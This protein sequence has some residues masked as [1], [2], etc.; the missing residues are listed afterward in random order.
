MQ[1][2]R[3]DVDLWVHAGLFSLY[4]GTLSVFGVTRRLDPSLGSAAQ[5]GLLLLTWSLL[6]FAVWRSKR[7]PLGGVVLLALLPYLHM[8]YFSATGESA[9]GAFSYLY[10]FSGFLMA[11]YLWVWA[12]FRDDDQIERTLMLVA[13]LLAARAVL[14]FAVPGLAIT[15]GGFADDFTVYEWVGPLPR[16]FY[17]GMPLVFFGLMVSLRNLFLAADRQTTLE[18]ARSVL[19]AAALAVNLSR[20]I[21]MFAVVVTSLLLLVKFT[22]SRVAAGRKGRLVLMSLLALTGVTLVVVATPLSDT[23]AQVASG[24]SNQ[25]RFSLDQGNLDWRV[26]QMRAAYRMVETPEERALGVGTNTFIPESIEHPVPGEV[27][28]ELH[29]S[30]DS[31][32]WTFGVAGLALLVGFALLQ[33]VLRVL[34]IRPTSPLILPV[35][36]TGSFIA[37]VGLYTVVFTTTDWSFVLSLCGALLNTRCDAWR[38]APFPVR[39]EPLTFPVPSQG[40]PHD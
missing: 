31:V 21:M 38:A 33:P 24:F 8:I 34:V 32:R 37:L 25:E 7:V 9:G 19:F 1:L 17:P 6:V 29:Y 26:E 18:L 15:S 40:V 3:R 30:Y 27:T 28:N 16:I 23:V 5:L 11:P 39:S 35:V 36:M 20:G 14:S 2:R 4:L 10:K 12:R 22:S 13:S